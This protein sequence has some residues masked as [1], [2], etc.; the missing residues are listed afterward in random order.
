MSNICDNLTGLFVVCYFIGYTGATDESVMSTF[1]IESNMLGTLTT[2]VCA[3]L[4]V[5]T[6]ADIRRD[7][8][9]VE[10]GKQLEGA[11]EAGELE[12]LTVVGWETNER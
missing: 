11:M 1:C 10:L 6:L 3:A 5:N 2:Q 7:P 4:K 12:A 9:N 8:G